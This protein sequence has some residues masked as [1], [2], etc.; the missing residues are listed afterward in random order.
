MTI[1]VATIDGRAYGI[2][3]REAEAWQ[4]ARARHGWIAHTSRWQRVTRSVPLAV[5]KAI[6]NSDTPPI[7]SEVA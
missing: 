2:G 4:D 1:F 3:W 6:A 5:A 7:L